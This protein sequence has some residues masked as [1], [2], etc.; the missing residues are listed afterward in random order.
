MPKPKKSPK[1][2]A[3]KAPASSAT[4]RRLQ[5][6]KRIWY[7]PLTWR[8]RQ[9]V[10]PYKPLPKARVLFATSLKQLWRNKR[11]F[12]SIVALYGV[13]NIVLVR[14][15]GGSSDLTTLKA[16]LD[17]ALHG[18][19]GKLATSFVSFTYLLTTSGSGN[20]AGS[21]IYQTILLLV[22]SLAL[23]WALRQVQA[24]HKVRMR[25]SFYSGMYPLI[26]FLLVFLL[27]SLQLVPLIVGAGIYSTLVTGG[28][29]VHAWEKLLWITLFAVLAFW[30]LRMVTATIFA[31]YVVTLPDM[32]PLRAYRS[33]R[34]LVYGRRL[35]LWRK[36]IFLPVALLLLAALIELPLILYVTPVAP[37]VFFA[38]S[39]LTLPIVHSYLYNLYREM[40]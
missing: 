31:A 18:F 22:C 11:L 9:P 1:S 25:D 13:L 30:S 28:I 27:L 20:A 6:P 21:G 33:A 5:V 38:L 37:W 36:L 35:L 34:Q 15:L 17:S 10:P 2:S 23:I 32:T 8:Y 26:P 40:L 14:G 3:K 4:P 39:M 29:A 12:G 19:G 7:K 24:G 16:S